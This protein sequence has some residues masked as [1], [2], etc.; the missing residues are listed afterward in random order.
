[1]VLNISRSVGYKG[2]L[3]RLSGM[4][5]MDYTIYIVVDVKSLPPV[6]DLTYNTH[7]HNSI[8][9]TKPRALDL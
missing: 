4:K 5:R 1:M 6:S 2:D 3:I 9:I 8:L 7:S